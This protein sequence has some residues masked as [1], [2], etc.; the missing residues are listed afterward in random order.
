MTDD[1]LWEYTGAG[2]SYQ[3]K[4]TGFV[5]HFD[6]SRHDTGWNHPD[7]QGRLPALMRAV[8][9]DMLTL[10]D[11][12]LEIEGRHAT[13]EELRLV[14]SATYLEQIRE[15]VAQSATDGK[16]IEPVANIR[17]SAASW[18]AATAAVGCV[19]TAIDS[20]VS[21]EVRNAFC[22]I[23]PPGR[24]ASADA[25]GGFGLLNASAVATQYLLD[26]GIEPLLVIEWGGSGES[27]TAKIFSAEP[28]VKVVA[29]STPFRGFSEAPGV[30]R[31]ED[32]SIRAQRSKDGEDF[33]EGVE[34]MLADAGHGPLPAFILLSAGFDG[35]R[36]DPVGDAG[37]SPRNYFDATVQVRDF[38]ERF[39]DG[40]LV[41]FLEGGYGGAL[42]EA[43]VQ[44]L[45]A[46]AGL[47]PAD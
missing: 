21:G 40:R 6:C 25:P 1:D 43:A 11:P 45:R 39:C 17:I 10:F 30:S 32:P 15:W 38:A 14:H 34:A 12:L 2:A 44:H 31:A 5:S 26:R 28:R 19:L 22:A 18:D 36:G 46:L 3:V 27:A 8:Y 24:Y 47:P 9:R 13:E 20:V 41:S 23:R 42:G 33:I 7:H 35:V 4:V 29:P 16:V 37:L